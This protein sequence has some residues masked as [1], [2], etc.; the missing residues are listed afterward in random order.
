MSGIV[1]GLVLAVAAS[2]ALNGAYLL[3]H[4]GAAQAPAIT[5]RR[6]VATLRGLL[7]SHAWLA[8]LGL[9]LG[10]WALHV[11]ALSLAPLSLVQAF[12][13]GGLVFCVPLAV[14]ELGH[15]V[16][17]A[18]AGGVALMAGALALLSAGLR[19]GALHR[20]LPA[21]ALAAYLGGALVLAA[22][23]AAAPAPSSAAGAERAA[24][25]GLA[26]GVLY[27]AAD[28]SIKAL[29]RI[30]ADHKLGAVATSP[31]LAV[32]AVATVGA[33][34]AFQR[35]LQLGRALPVIALMTAATNLVSILG[36]LAVL[37]EPLGRTPA[38][39]AAHLLAFGLVGLAAWLLAPAQAALAAPGPPGD[40]GVA[41]GSHAGEQL[42][43]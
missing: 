39:A 9:G 18:E 6:P 17:R 20:A 32:A 29:T 35:G 5:P 33:F 12:V 41:L 23:L 43:R 13:A 40:V 15:R 22:V 34:F 3:Q 14:R 19:E 10:G 21:G 1:L 31:W 36:G 4:A 8:G 37:G 30:G 7:S 38:L 28:L 16:T 11:A 25:L 24:R 26:G 27:G 2:L 42:P